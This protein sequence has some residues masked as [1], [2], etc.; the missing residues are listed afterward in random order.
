MGTVVMSAL[1]HFQ[2]KRSAANSGRF[3]PS[4]VDDLVKLSNCASTIAPVEA[5]AARNDV[6]EC[7]HEHLSTR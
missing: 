2:T 1:C 5:R 7:E 4:S 6:E 3:D